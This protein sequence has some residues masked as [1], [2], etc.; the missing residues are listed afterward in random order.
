MAVKA[1]EQVGKKDPTIRWLARELRTQR[2]ELLFGLQTSPWEVLW[3]LKP[4]LAPSSPVWPSVDP[5][6][7][8]TIM[9]A[10]F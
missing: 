6:G 8:R 3:A 9:A 5:P 7:L 2:A 4:L 1:E 10:K